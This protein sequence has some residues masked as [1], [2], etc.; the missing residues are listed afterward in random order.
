MADLQLKKRGYI[1]EISVG[2]N[3]ALAAISA[4]FFSLS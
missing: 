2:F 3:A 4:K 1:W